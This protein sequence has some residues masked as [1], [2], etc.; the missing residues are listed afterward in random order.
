M[1][2]VE[3]P[4]ISKS[5]TPDLAEQVT[6]L[7]KLHAD[8]SLSDEEFKALKAK[9]LEG[10]AQNSQSGSGPSGSFSRDKNNIGS[11]RT[12]SSLDQI[13]SDSKSWIKRNPVATWGGTALIAVPI[14]AMIFS[15]GFSSDSVP[16]QNPAT[17]DPSSR[18]VEDR[19]K[20]PQFNSAELVIHNSIPFVSEGVKIGEWVD[21]DV[22][23]LN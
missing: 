2:S 23:P 1:L 19:E 11:G 18:T 20:Y 14:I 7:A 21:C 13:M 6:K 3:I 12:T 22:A 17:G 10:D 5:N 16:V 4:M 15:S 9:L 8:G